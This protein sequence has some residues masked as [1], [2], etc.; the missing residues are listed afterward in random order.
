MVVSEIGEMLSPNVAPPLRR[1]G[2]RWFS[3]CLRLA[4]GQGLSDPTSGLWAAN[5]RAAALLAEQYAS[6]YPEVDALV[7]LVRHGCTIAE[8]PVAMRARAAGS[9]S[10]DAPRALYYMLKVTVALGIG[11][12]RARA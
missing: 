11:R 8:V 5:A 1:L 6:D 4:C 10:I 12:L 2:S 3:L 9:S 7:H